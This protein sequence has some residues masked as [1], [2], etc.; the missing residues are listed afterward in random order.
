MSFVPLS[1][2]TTRIRN[3]M[4]NNPYQPPSSACEPIRSRFSRRSGIPV[5]VRGP[6]FAFLALIALVL[7]NI[8]LAALYRDL[9]SATIWLPAGLLIAGYLIQRGCSAHCRSAMKLT[10]ICSAITLALVLLV[11]MRV[12]YWNMYFIGALSLLLTHTLANGWR[13]VIA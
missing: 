11:L 13:R 7:P 2:A 6:L 12:G 9:D 4:D 10:T 5:A 1:R 3:A 8:I